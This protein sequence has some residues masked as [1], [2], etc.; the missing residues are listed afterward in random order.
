MASPDDVPISTS[1]PGEPISAL[2]KGVRRAAIGKSQSLNDR[3]AEKLILDGDPSLAVELHD[4]IVAAAVEIPLVIAGGVV[5]L[6]GV[7]SARIRN[8]VVTDPRT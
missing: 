7:Q 5:Q 1:F 2:E 8:D 6:E 3:G 4:Q